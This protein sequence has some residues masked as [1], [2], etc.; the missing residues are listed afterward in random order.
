MTEINIDEDDVAAVRPTLDGIALETRTRVLKFVC[1]SQ[2]TSAAFRVGLLCRA[3]WDA[4]EM[5]PY[6]T[7]LADKEGW[8][9]GPG[10]RASASF[11]SAYVKRVWKAVCPRCRDLVR[12][13]RIWTVEHEDRTQARLCIRCV[14]TIGRCGHEWPEDGEVGL[15]EHADPLAVQGD[16]DLDVVALAKLP[17]ISSSVLAELV[18]TTSG[19]NSG[20]SPI[21][22]FDDSGYVV[23]ASELDGF[24]NMSFGGPA[25]FRRL[26]AHQ[27]ASTRARATALVAEHL[28]A[29]SKAIGI[30]LT[31]DGTHPV[32]DSTDRGIDPARL[33][34][35]VLASLATD[36]NPWGLRFPQALNLNPEGVLE[37]PAAWWAARRADLEEKLPALSERD[38]LAARAWDS[39]FPSLAL[40]DPALSRL[41]GLALARFPEAAPEEILRSVRLGAYL[42]GPSSV[43]R[44]LWGD[45]KQVIADARDDVMRRFHVDEDDFEYRAGD[46]EEL[47]DVDEDF[48]G[49]DQAVADFCRR[50]VIPEGARRTLPADGELDY[51]DE[52]LRVTLC[53]K[54]RSDAALA[55][56]GHVEKLV[57][58]TLASSGGSTL[59]REKLLDPD[60]LPDAE[61]LLAALPPE[62][63]LVIPETVSHQKLHELVRKERN[64]TVLEILA[65]RL[66]SAAAAGMPL[67]AAEALYCFSNDPRRLS[68][69][70]ASVLAA[71]PALARFF[72]SD[73]S[74]QRT[75]LTRGSRIGWPGTEGP[76]FRAAAEA[77]VRAHGWGAAVS[78]AGT[79]KADSRLHNL[80][81]TGLLSH[82]KAVLQ[83]LARTAE[84]AWI[85]PRRD[86]KTERELR[87]L[88]GDESF[89]DSGGLL[90]DL[91]SEWHHYVLERR[92]RE[93]KDVVEAAERPRPAPAPAPQQPSS[94]PK[95][96]AADGSRI[97]FCDKCGFCRSRLATLEMMEKHPCGL[98]HIKRA[99]ST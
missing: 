86:G 54:I 67:D 44:T 2:G 83:E 26:V 57:S 13:D 31:F 1:D 84:F 45:W 80:L 71:D 25:N 38:T 93:P 70:M 63:A 49:A 53:G 77:V 5:L 51:L 61:E 11:V 64:T 69:W 58:R 78:R 42:E 17:G 59:A 6:W 73:V 18:T 4:Y 37:E 40:P 22:F 75:L 41:F 89:R 72:P 95:P 81:T 9:R 28:P 20:E 43:E 39:A 34:G 29:L 74:E 3:L 60:V 35:R 76:V 19:E 94:K 27:I 36:A 82:G 52:Q 30:P 16:A 87:K 98:A 91:A 15:L 8:E 14:A 90:R 85:W 92:R 97:Y 99:N 88:L 48:V 23:P 62:A 24:V 56:A 68:A 7:R 47:P 10:Q 46:W 65:Q 79:A 66:A 12:R 32:I 96:T 33:A 21:G 55:L 50:R